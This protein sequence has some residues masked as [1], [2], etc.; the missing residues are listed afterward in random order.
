MNGVGV[1][2]DKQLLISA[3]LAQA[4]EVKQLLERGADANVK[5]EVIN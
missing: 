1:S 2:V 5:D 4:Y 3:S